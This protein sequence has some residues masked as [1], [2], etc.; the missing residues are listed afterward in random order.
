[1]SLVA[2]SRS[3]VKS[4]SVDANNA[5]AERKKREVYLFND[6]L[7]IAKPDGDKY[8]LLNMVSFDALSVSLVDAPED[9]ISDL[10]QL[11]H[12]V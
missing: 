10:I 1:M 8:K 9:G 2:P 12:S 4:G 3:L 11:K 6:M 7:V 5:H